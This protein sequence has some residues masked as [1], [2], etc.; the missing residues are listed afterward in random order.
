MAFANETGDAMDEHRRFAGASARHNQHGP[1][2]M[3]DGLLLLWV[4]GYCGSVASDC[5]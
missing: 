5:H 1:G 3:L 4:G 2:Y